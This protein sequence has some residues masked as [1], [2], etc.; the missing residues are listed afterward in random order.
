MSKIISI[1]IMVSVLTA[2]NGIKKENLL[3]ADTNDTVLNF[4]DALKSYKAQEHR[5]EIKACKLY[6]NEQHVV[7]DSLHLF[8]KV[9]GDSFKGRITYF[10]DDKPISF[11]ARRLGD[12][13][14]L[15]ETNGIDNRPRMVASI[16]I[17][18][19]D[20][21]EVLKDIADGYESMVSEREAAFIN[22]PTLEG[23]VLIDG[24]LINANTKIKDFNKDR[25]NNKLPLYTPLLG[26]AISQGITYG[27]SYCLPAYNSIG[28]TNVTLLYND[29][30]YLEKDY[31]VTTIK[32]VRYN[33]QQPY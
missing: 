8:E 4:Q 13:H 25:K 11:K 22:L 3:A 5:F 29:E 7:L 15:E 14:N 31:Q 16:A 26:M 21:T 28:Y 24:Q 9:M 19:S 33:Y 18:L 23:Y 30:N 27:K 6:Y 10:Y 1:L 12:I 32:E 17:K 2:C 20:D